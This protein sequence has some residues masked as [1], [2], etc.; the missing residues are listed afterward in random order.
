MTSTT[1]LPSAC[2]LVYTAP[3]PKGMVPEKHLWFSGRNPHRKAG[4]RFVQILGTG[5]PALV[6]HGFGRDGPTRK[7]GR[8]AEPVFFTPHPPAAMKTQTVA[9]LSHSGAKTMTH[10]TQGT[11]MPAPATSATPTQAHQLFADACNCAAMASWYT[12]R[13]NIPAAARKARQHLA[14]LRQLAKLEGGA[15]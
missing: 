10:V 5:A 2:T 4:F 6:P 14:A 13:G 3:V 15:A 12:R 11:T 9:H 1:T 7:D 8:T